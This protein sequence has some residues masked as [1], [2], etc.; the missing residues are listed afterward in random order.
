MVPGIELIP[1]RQLTLRVK[2]G[3]RE[4]RFAARQS[5]RHLLQA[6]QEPAARLPLFAPPLDQ[7][8]QTAW[9]L[10]EGID[11]VAVDLLSSAADYRRMN[12]RL[13]SVT[14]SQ[15]VTGAQA[16]PFQ[17][18]FYWTLKHL[19]ERERQ[20]GVTVHE[21]ALFLAWQAWHPQDGGA[22]AG[23]E[24]WPGAPSGPQAQSLACARLV[25]ALMASRPLHWH[26][27]WS[28]EGRPPHQPAQE[29][30]AALTLQLV[31]AAVLAG[32]VAAAY[33]RSAPADEV[34]NA[35][36]LAATLVARR[37]SP[38]QA[39]W[40]SANPLQALTREF[41]FVLRHL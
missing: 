14:G 7:A 38:W 39:A 10:L 22:Q 28:G 29:R 2:D 20:E 6:L 37:M 1:R 40:T 26:A 31:I 27:D 5:A 21:E 3:V 4:L 19:L 23:H 25:L 12:Y 35:L 33:P 16:Q 24:A 18:H 32:E 9:Q 15:R 34:A 8:A 13:L 30:Q 36:H 17:R 41:A 11:R